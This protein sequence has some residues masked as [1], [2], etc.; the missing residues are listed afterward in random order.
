MRAPIEK[1]CFVAAALAVIMVVC[2]PATRV[3]AL[4]I[5]GQVVNG[6]TNTPVN[7]ITIRVVNPSGGMRIER[8]VE[9]TDD[10]GHF[11]IDGLPDAPIYL[12]RVTYEGVNYTE[13]VQSASHNHH[14]LEFN[15]YER[16]DT[17]EGVKVTAPHV[18]LSRSLDTL[19]VDKFIQVSNETSPPKTIYGG[20]EGFVF[21]LPEDL[22]EIN[23]I[24]I[25]SLGIPL[26]MTPTATG[27]PGFYTLDYPIKPGVTQISA[28]L[29]LPYADGRY[30]YNEQL[31]YDIEEM[32]VITE[33]PGIAVTSSTTAI[34]E[35]EDFHGFKAYRLTGLTAG[36]PLE[37]TISGGSSAAAHGSMPQISVVYNQTHG[38]ALVMMIV[39]AAMLAGFLLMIARRGRTPGVE[40]EVLSAQKEELLGQL[41][42]LDDLHKTGTLSEQVYGMKR[43]EL[44][45]ALAQIYY[46]MRIDS[47]ANRQKAEDKKKPASV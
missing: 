21:Y 44:V 14:Q 4:D 23:S 42:R 9:T 45:N 2:A 33:D 19:T 20:D 40:E 32:L 46:R 22:L 31:K 47:S 29:D 16:T 12:V 7:P 36:K 18:L 10:L 41:A 8:E 1:W 34:G 6:T 27:E 28:S 17:W 30:N 43:T 26:P 35:A 5:H 3:A 37:L 39:V 13:V 11:R 25:R 38:V 15:V 24:S